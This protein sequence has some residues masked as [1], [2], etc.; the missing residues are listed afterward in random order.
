M[1]QDKQNQMKQSIGYRNTKFK[2]PS[3]TMNLHTVDYNKSKYVIW[4]Q[5]QLKPN[6]M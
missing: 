3:N 4:R 6:F 1:C 5:L 2:G